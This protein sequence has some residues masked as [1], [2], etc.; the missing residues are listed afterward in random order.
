[1]KLTFKV[2]DKKVKKL[3]TFSDFEEFEAFW[4]EINLRRCSKCS[5]GRRSLEREA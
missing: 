4:I 1:M 3:L 5:N 2:V